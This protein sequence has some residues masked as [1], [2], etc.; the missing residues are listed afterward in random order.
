MKNEINTWFPVKSC[1]KLE[2]KEE[3]DEIRKG[4]GERNQKKKKSSKHIPEL[5][6]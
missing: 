2:T 3:K 6:N 5:Q 1:K 4:N